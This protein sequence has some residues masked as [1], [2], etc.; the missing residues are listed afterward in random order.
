MTDQDQPLIV[1]HGDFKPPP[2]SPDFIALEASDMDDSPGISMTSPPLPNATT[3]SRAFQSDGQ[4]AGG[5]RY[6]INDGDNKDAVSD[7]ADDYGLN[8]RSENY[9][10]NRRDQGPQHRCLSRPHA[11][12]LKPTLLSPRMPERRMP[13]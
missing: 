3:I 10:P 13:P 6:Q 11:R 4:D 12:L 1:E 7:V 5:A 8:G 2:P 9:D